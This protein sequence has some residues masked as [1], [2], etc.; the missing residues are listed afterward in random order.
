MDIVKCVIVINIKLNHSTASAFGK[1]SMV[2]HLSM[3]I[4]L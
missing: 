1:I 3:Q 2:F 4:I